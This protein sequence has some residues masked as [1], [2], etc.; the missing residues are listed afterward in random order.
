MAEENYENLD[1]DLESLDQ[2]IERTNKVEERI[3]DLSS[4]VRL[5]AEERDEKDKLLKERDEQLTNLTKENQFLSSFTD[6]T[7][8]YPNAHEYRDAIKEKVLS[9]YDPEDA[10]VAVLAKEGKLGGTPAP[11]VPP[12]SPIGGSATTVTTATGDKPL[13]ELTRDELREALKESI[14]RGDITL[15]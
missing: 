6:L 1:L 12:E 14:D 2:N 10:A 5:T 15:S 7:A 9:G 3:K 11:I 13:N 8:K 4:K